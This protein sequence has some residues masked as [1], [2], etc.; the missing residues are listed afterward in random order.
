MAQQSLAT[1]VRRRSSLLIHMLVWLA[2]PAGEWIVGRG[3]SPG[4][5]AWQWALECIAFAGLGA[6]QWR[7]ADEPWQRT[8]LWP[9]LLVVLS[10][11]AVA[12]PAEPLRWQ[13][14]YLAGIVLLVTS[15]IRDFCE[16]FDV[17]FAIA[18]VLAIAS[19]IANRALD[20]DT[21]SGQI[22]AGF[23]GARTSGNSS[24]ELAYELRGAASSPAPA[25]PGGPPIVVISIDTLRADAAPSM[26]SW[27]RLSQKGAWW[28]TTVSSSSWTLPAVASIQT[29]RSV[30]TH[31]AD[32]V[33]DSGC[34][35]IDPSVA[36][37][38]ENLSRRGYA[39]A[40]FT[41]NPWITRS[42][43]LARGFQTFRDFAGVPPFRLTLAG[44]PAGLPAQD[45]AVVTSQAIEWLRGS[46]GPSIYLWV[47]LIGP[48]MPYMHST[49]AKLQSIT[50]EALRTGGVTGPEFRVAVRKAYDDEVAYND[51]EVM[52]LLDVLDEQGVLNRGV[53]VLTSDHGEEFWEHGGIEHGHSHHRE[54]TEV[55]LVIA[56]PGIEPGERAG[57]ASLIDL[58]PTLEALAGL[59]ADGL[60]LRKPLPP[61][62]IATSYG[63]LYGGTMRSARDQQERVIGSRRGLV[64]ERWDRYDLAADPGEQNPLPADPAGNVYREASA[65]E[66]PVAGKAADVNKSALKSLGYAQ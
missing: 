6:L 59:E 28:T 41:A 1:D 52:R 35:G 49:N 56:A 47:H 25:G 33:I 4:P 24:S 46:H 62:R 21:L 58:A 3:L 63:N 27:K 32:C 38:A 13:L 51:H 30:T 36:T 39:T 12:G 37:L 11:L 19:P 17:P 45:S 9:S 64:G 26:E 29:G 65:I 10:G 14:F 16:R 20:L 18:L 53:V 40:A 44:P 23:G 8:L 66:S 22:S 54:V 7:L 2:V 55:P 15:L 57:V 48:H 61:G 50:G 43:G 31:G 42:T 60:D 34:Q 5:A